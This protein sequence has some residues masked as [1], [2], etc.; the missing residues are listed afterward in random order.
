MIRS[1]PERVLFSLLSICISATSER[2]LSF[3]WE[4]CLLNLYLTTTWQCVVTVIN[5]CHN[6][7]FWCVTHS[8]ELYGKHVVV[9]W[10]IIGK[11][12][13]CKKLYRKTSTAEGSKTWKIP[14]LALREITVATRWAW[15]VTFRNVMTYF[16]AI[17]YSKAVS[18]HTL[19]CTCA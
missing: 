11:K 4:Y 5:T 8:Q 1:S 14:T 13:K 16:Q 3:R 2:I 15:L 9:A 17:S 7:F 12:G 6:A 18:L 10:Y 19:L